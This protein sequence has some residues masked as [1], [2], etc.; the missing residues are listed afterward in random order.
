MKNLTLLNDDTN[1]KLGDTGTL[2]QF[3]ASDD[4]APVFLTKGQSAVFRIK[5]DLGFLKSINAETTMGGYVFQFDTSELSGLVAGTYQLEL[6]ITKS[7][8]DIEIYP[9]N[10]FVQFTI[11]ENAL[12]IIGEQLPMMGLDTFKK[13]I[14]E[15]VSNQ[16]NGAETAIKNDFQKY[17]TSI[18]NNTIDKAN[19]ASQDAKSA[20][21]TANNAVTT[22]NSANAKSTANSVL[23]QG[24]NTS[25]SKITNSFGGRNLLLDSRTGQS[26]A[27][28]FKNKNN[29]DEKYMECVVGKTNKAWD[30]AIGAYDVYDLYQR[31]L[32]NTTDTYTFSC[33][34][35]TDGTITLRRGDISFYSNAT[36]SNG[37][38][39]DVS[40]INNDTW[41]RI[42]ITFK[43]TQN[44]PNK[45]DGT[46]CL[47]FEPNVSWSGLSSHAGV[48]TGY[49]YLACP[50][51]ERG[52]VSTDYTPAP[53]DIS[54]AQAIL[55]QQLATL[56]TELAKLKA[57]GA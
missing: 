21:D 22:A 24:T 38:G 52:T 5:N 31:D 53:E 16:V 15:Y 2:M 33:C 39:V 26:S 29:A 57:G 13:E 19:K 49:L 14:N 34:A 28:L 7:A 11:S 27:W 54:D 6:A 41:T 23:I 36:D 51:L 46:L 32:Y 3:K 40:Q 56:T 25:L 48:G 30:K 4:N 50:K 18:S 10:G 47:R 9:D 55:Q 17:V 43:F 12:S 37:K 35:K 8:E 1:V 45:N 20:I 44:V 42:S